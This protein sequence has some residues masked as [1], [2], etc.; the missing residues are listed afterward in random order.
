MQ[1]SFHM[2][3]PV[4]SAVRFVVLTSASE[5]ICNSTLSLNAIARVDGYVDRFDLID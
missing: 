1:I 2:W 5:F 3:F 4:F